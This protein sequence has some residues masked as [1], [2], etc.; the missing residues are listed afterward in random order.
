MQKCVSF[1]E[2]PQNGA[3][4]FHAKNVP[5]PILVHFV[6]S[7]QFLHRFGAFLGVSKKETHHFG[8]EAVAVAVL[9]KITNWPKMLLTS[10]F[11]TWYNRSKNL[12]QKLA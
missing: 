3:F 9:H 8:A 4:L 1:L 11:K 10:Y 5:S 6:K 7:R 12:R 2:T